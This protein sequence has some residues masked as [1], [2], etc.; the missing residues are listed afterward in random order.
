MLAVE[1]VMQR[2]VVMMARAAL[3][4][5]LLLPTTL[6]AQD[7]PIGSD[8]WALRLSVVASG[9]SYESE[10]T[11]YKMYS[12]IALEAGVVR[13]VGEMLS[14]E[15]SAR[16]ESREVNGP[17]L[18]G[19]PERL[20]SIELL[21]LNFI[22]SWH[23]LARS[24]RTVQPVVGAGVNFTDI[25]EKSGALDSTESK[26]TWS[27]VVQGSTDVG[28][29]NRTVLKLQVRWQLLTIDIQDFAPTAPSV[30]I[31]PLSIGVGVQVTL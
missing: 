9:A 26:P 13:W 11:G 7:A 22:A 1:N 23:P 15:L 25:W 5:V 19:V 17:P 6:L 10:P 3:I 8:Q 14:L 16:T 29:S 31:D 12:G 18:N 20:G 28:L 4:A 2:N 27:P 24:R 30:S 21:P